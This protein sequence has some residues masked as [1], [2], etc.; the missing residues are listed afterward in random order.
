MSTD[1][2]ELPAWY[3]AGIALMAERVKLGVSSLDL[4]QNGQRASLPKV[5]AWIVSGKL[6]SQ[7]GRMA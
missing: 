4:E 2:L 1:E 6:R 7:I 5:S 3:Q